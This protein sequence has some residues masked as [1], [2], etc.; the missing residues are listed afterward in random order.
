MCLYKAKILIWFNLRLFKYKR[1]MP[2]DSNG[3]EYV[4]DYVT[5]FWWLEVSI[6]VCSDDIKWAETA[7]YGLNESKSLY[8]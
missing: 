6:S 5:P 4:P 7:K 8:F 3:C 2:G 1:E